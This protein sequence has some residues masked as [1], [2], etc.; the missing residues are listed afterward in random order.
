MQGVEILTSRQ[1]IT[2]CVCNWNTFWITFSVIFTFCV[3]IMIIYSA[4]N[5]FKWSVL[6]T[7]CICGVIIGGMIGSFIGCIDMVPTAYETQYKITISDEVSMTEFLEHYEVIDQDGKI[8]TVR[9][10]T[11]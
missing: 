9:E 2:D 10:K 6:L 11:K 5:G 1:I 7:C 4:A 3:V 8:F